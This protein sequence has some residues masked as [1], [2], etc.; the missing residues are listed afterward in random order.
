MVVLNLVHVPSSPPNQVVLL[1][2]DP[3]LK[4]E[5]AMTILAP[6][7]AHGMLGLIGPNAMP[8]ATV[9]TNLALVP[10]TLLNSV[11]L[12]VLASITKL[13]FATT[14]LAIASGILGKNGQLAPSL[15]EEVL[16]PVIEERL[17]LN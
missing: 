3:T 11:V 10:T 12:I 2:Q 1:A 7:T 8:L 4:V 16:K 17:K 9:V 6:L 14:T 5:L 15:A 13:L